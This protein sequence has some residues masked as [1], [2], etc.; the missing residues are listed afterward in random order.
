MTALATP[1]NLLRVVVELELLVAIYYNYAILRNMN[2]DLEY[3]ATR[4]F[5]S[6]KSVKGIKVVLLTLLAYSVLNTV[7]V[8]QLQGEMRDF[9]LKLIILG[10]FGGLTY[11]FRQIASVTAKRAG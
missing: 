5:L 4:I 11:F 7:V 10:L 9:V 8:F 2:R 3:S 1:D 6:P